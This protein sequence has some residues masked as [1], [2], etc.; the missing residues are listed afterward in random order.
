MLCSKEAFKTWTDLYKSSHATAELDFPKFVKKAFNKSASPGG[1]LELLSEANLAG[2][3]TVIEG[4]E[5]NDYFF[6]L[7]HHVHRTSQDCEAPQDDEMY[8][9]INGTE[10]ADAEQGRTTFVVQVPRCAFAEKV[11]EPLRVPKVTAFCEF[12]DKLDQLT[13]DLDKEDSEVEFENLDTTKGVLV[14]PA[15]VARSMNY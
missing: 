6:G 11:T 4:E 2:I 13:P 9:A 5:V 8:F 7:W 1:N 15:L 10:F 14:P 12:L 3:L